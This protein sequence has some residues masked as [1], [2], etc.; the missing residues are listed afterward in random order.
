MEFAV[1]EATTRDF[2]IAEFFLAIANA[3][4]IVVPDAF[5]ALGAV[6]VYPGAGTLTRDFFF[7]LL[8]LF[9]VLLFDKH[10]ARVDASV[11]LDLLPVALIIQIWFKIVDS[12]LV[13]VR[14]DLT[15]ELFFASV[16]T[17]GLLKQTWLVL[18]LHK[19]QGLLLIGRVLLKVA[20]SVFL[21]NQSD[22]CLLV[23]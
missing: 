12:I 6:L 23:N 1:Y 13:F 16:L 17:R 11:D 9:I 22:W 8:V 20:S 19:R 18:R 15:F 3:E 14:V 21:L 4:V 5:E 7:S 2:A 10:V